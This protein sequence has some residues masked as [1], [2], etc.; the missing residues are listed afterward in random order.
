LQ[1]EQPDVAEYD[2]NQDASIPAS[3]AAAAA[4][5]FSHLAASGRQQQQLRSCSSLKRSSKGSKHTNPDGTPKPR[6][7]SGPKSKFSP[8]IGVSQYKRTGRWEVSAATACAA[9]N[10]QTAVTCQWRSVLCTNCCVSFS[11]M[12]PYSA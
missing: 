3:A 10:M 8:F 6:G 4:V 9:H 11:A 2:P 1:Q 7:R 12:H 5:G